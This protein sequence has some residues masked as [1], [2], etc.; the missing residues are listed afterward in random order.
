MTALERRG[1]WWR[2]ALVLIVT[3]L[4][5]VPLAGTLSNALGL[6][7]IH[8]PAGPAGLA[9]PGRS[10]AAGIRQSFASALQP[11]SS[12]WFENSLMLALG[13]VVVCIVLGAPAGY[14]LARGRGRL[15]SGYALAIFLL[16]SFPPVML[17]V[18]LFLMFA[19]VHLIDNL[20]GLG[21]VYL[22]LTLSF[23]I[24]MCAAYVDTIPIELEEAAW[25]DG[26]SVFGAFF[27]VVLRNALP[28]MLTVAIFTFLTVWNEYMAAL[29]FLRSINNY[30]LGVGLQA[31]G[32]SPVLAVVMALPPVLVFVVLNRY[33]SLGGVAGSLAGQ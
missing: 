16:Q 13:A 29:I 15:V 27:R 24:W 18:P 25:I 11:P 32:H 19:R 17:I 6:P 12:Y 31:A 20:F 28:A 10:W 30:T 5:L 23:A 1:R 7:G 2:F 8:G 33:F 4:V 3:A 26:C 14:V 22:A 9:G 21:L